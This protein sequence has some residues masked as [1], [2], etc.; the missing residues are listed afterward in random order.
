[1]LF[2]FFCIHVCG[3]TRPDLQA[4]S[5]N[6]DVRARYLTGHRVYTFLSLQ[7]FKVSVR[8]LSL[9][10][11]IMPPAVPAKR[12]QQK[13]PDP[14][15]GQNEAKK[16]R[17]LASCAANVKPVATAPLEAPLE[18]PEKKTKTCGSVAESSLPTAKV[19]EITEH[20][21]SSPPSQPGGSQRPAPSIQKDP[22]PS[23]AA[24]AMGFVESVRAQTHANSSKTLIA[25]KILEPLIP[26]FK[27]MDQELLEPASYGGVR[28]FSSDHYVES[29]KDGSC[30]CTIPF[31]WIGLVPC[32]ENCLL[33]FWVCL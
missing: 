3:P 17:T 27:K 6:N 1:M 29:M 2:S 13:T 33:G 21:L 14:Q 18:T 32:S 10:C 25:T 7:I 11:S 30:A 24:A 31:S 19:A 26:I 4:M 5:L 22:V 20:V 16:A 12:M 8:L 15:V 9:D 28:A 23:I